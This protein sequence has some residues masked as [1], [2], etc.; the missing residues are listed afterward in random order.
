MKTSWWKSTE[1]IESGLKY[2]SSK[3]CRNWISPRLVSERFLNIKKFSLFATYASYF[4]TWF[5]LKVLL[6]AHYYG[7]E[8]FHFQKYAYLWYIH[9]NLVQMTSIN[10]PLNIL[11]IPHLNRCTYTAV[12]EDSKKQNLESYLS[13]VECFTLN[14]DHYPSSSERNTENITII[15]WNVFSAVVEYHFYFFF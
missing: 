12:Y 11:C 15:I 14:I 13:R 2:K 6:E 1:N 5:G 7:L 10:L 8:V 3:F 4:I 9:T